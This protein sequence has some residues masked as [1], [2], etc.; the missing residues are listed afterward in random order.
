M[1]NKEEERK[2]LNRT[3]TPTASPLT[4]LEGSLSPSPDSPDSRATKKNSPKKRAS[5]A[6]DDDQPELPTP[7]VWHK[8]SVRQPLMMKNMTVYRG[9]K[10]E[11]SKTSVDD[12]GIA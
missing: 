1:E 3:P 5:T 9:G 6:K 7:K 10:K 11:Q 2:L 4:Q 8:I 12:E